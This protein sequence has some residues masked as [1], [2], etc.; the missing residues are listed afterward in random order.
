LK[1]KTGLHK[2]DIELIESICHDELVNFRSRKRRKIK[3]KLKSQQDT[4]LTPFNILLATLTFVWAYPKG[5][6][7][8]LAKDFGT[9]KRTIRDYIRKTLKVL[10]E[11]LEYLR[12]WPAS[13]RGR[14]D[15]GPFKNAVGCVDSF[16][17]FLLRPEDPSER[18]EFFQF[19][20]RSWAYKVQ[21]FVDIVT[22]RIMDIDQVYPYGKWADTVVY[23]KSLPFK[24]LDE[25]NWA[26]ALPPPDTTP[27]PTKIKEGLAD[28]GYKGIV[29]NY[30]T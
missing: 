28:K 5:G 16:P 25:N 6:Y 3:A 29:L 14:I 2:D 7:R 13:Y 30:S 17:V 23:R 18:S 12:R 1:L 15:S 24:K 21:V 26:V 19:K 4:Y 10:A 8:E 20:K 9:D 11:K 22:G 27:H